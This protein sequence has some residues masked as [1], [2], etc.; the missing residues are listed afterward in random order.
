MYFEY[1]KLAFKQFIIYYAFLLLC[2]SIVQVLFLNSSGP[3]E[4]L[5]S[6]A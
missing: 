1:V 4:T 6:I 2:A 3:A 5:A